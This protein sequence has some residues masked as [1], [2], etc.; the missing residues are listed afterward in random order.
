MAANFEG[1]PLIHHDGDGDGDDG[2]LNQQ[3]AT[4][5]GCGCFRAFSFK[6]WRRGG[7]DVDGGG[8]T[9][10]WMAEKLRKVKEAT[11]VIAGPKWKTFIRKAGGYFNNGGNKK[12]RR[13]QYD[14]HSYDLNF[15]STANSEDEADMPPSFSARFSA[16]AP[17]NNSR[18]QPQS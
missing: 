3:Q 1:K 16:P 5:C 6:N 2:D 13:F 8:T 15:N 18:P 14:Q 12:N 4:F 7:G 11:E 10:A 9:T 17:T